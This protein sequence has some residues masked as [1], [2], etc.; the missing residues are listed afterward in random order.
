VLSVLAPTGV[1]LNARLIPAGPGPS[2]QYRLGEEG[3]RLYSS[4]VALVTLFGKESVA[5]QSPCLDLSASYSYSLFRVC[6]GSFLLQQRRFLITEVST[7][8]ILL[9]RLIQGS[10][11]FGG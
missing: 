8:R 3:D 2:P 1:V 6:F 5:Q 4:I 11:L 10:I 9:S 7:F